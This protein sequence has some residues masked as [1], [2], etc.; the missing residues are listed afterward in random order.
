[1]SVIICHASVSENGD[2]GWN[3]KAKAGDQTGREVC[4]RSWYNKPFPYTIRYDKDSSLPKKWA[5]IAKK[6]AD[7]NLVGYDQSQRNTLYQALKAV[8]FDVDKYI[9]SGKKTETDCSAFVYACVCC[10][11]KDLR[12]NNN[13]PTTSTMKNFYESHG[14]KVYSD[15]SHTTTDVNLKTGDILV[16]PG[17]HTVMAIT[18]GQNVKD[19]PTVAE[20]TL[21]KGSSGTQVKLLQKNLNSLGYKDKNGKK[22]EVDG[23]FG[24]N[25]EYAL[26][27]FQKAKKLEVDGIYGKNS[28]NAI[29][30]A[31]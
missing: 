24:A 23:S 10:I 8:D 13:A 5:K 11:L 21:R 3:G 19:T 1:M 20:P 4:T 6:L 31:L 28:Y 9:K 29:K 17:S 25:T 2:A 18:D 12:S 22:L 15:A 14:F 26:K 16:K 27:A 30:K 7:S